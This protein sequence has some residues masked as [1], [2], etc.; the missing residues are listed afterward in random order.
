MNKSK[1]I[2][3]ADYYKV[4]MII[5]N[6]VFKKAINNLINQINKFGLWAP[7]NGFKTYKEYFEWNK[8]YFDNYAK[9]ENSEE[10]KNKV[11]KITKGEKRWGEKEQC[12]IED[13][14][15]KEL[16]PVYGSVI[17]DLLYQ[18][19][20]SSKDE[21]HK[22]FHDFII[23]YIFFKK[24]EFSN[25]NLQ[26]TWKL[27]HNTRQMELFIQILRCTRKQDL[28]NAWE[29]IRREQRGLPEFKSKNKE[30]KNFHRDLEI[31]SAYKLLRKQPTSKY[32]RASCAFNKRVDQQIKLKFMDK[33]GIEKWGT[34][35]SIVK[36]MENFKKNVGFNEPK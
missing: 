23:E 9:I 28:E 27:N 5:D 26:I 6:P 22:K 3:D 11:L 8:K 36:N 10:F 35:R 15:D 31:Y 20:I 30:Y 17:N 32:K 34:I 24:T 16:P 14:R 29:F 19:G 2:Y 4:Q 12:Q 33:Y 7:E 25:P 13:L 21:Q 1:K 18:F